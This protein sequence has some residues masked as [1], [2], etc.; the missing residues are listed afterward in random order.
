MPAF[1]SR[2][3][4]RLVLGL[5][6]LLPTLAWG[7]DAAQRALEGSWQLVGG[8]YLDAQ[9]QRVDYAAAKLVGTKVLSG[10][11]FAF[12]TQRDGKFW[13]GGSGTFTADGGRY[14]ETPQ[15]ASFPVVEGGSYRFDYTLEGDTWTLERH[16]DGRR[17]EYEVWHRVVHE[18]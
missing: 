2:S 15:I 9:G 14:V 18:R 8:E 5:L 12:S 11:Q 17:V 4:L 13:A 10:R 16:E 7:D 6:L 1:R 3:P